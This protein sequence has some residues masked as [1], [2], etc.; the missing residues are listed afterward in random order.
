[1]I[2]AKIFILVMSVYV[3]P[4]DAVDWN[5]PWEHGLVQHMN[6]KFKSESECLSAAAILKQQMQKG[7]LAP[8]RFA[9]VAFDQSLPEG[10][11]R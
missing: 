7:M 3:A 5:G 11:P 9:C 2:S 1:M 10:A 6:H 4:P 8:L